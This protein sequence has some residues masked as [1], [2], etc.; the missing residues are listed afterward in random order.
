MGRA[1]TIDE[2]G[3]LGPL[4]GE[5]AWH[6]ITVDA[7]IADRSRATLARVREI[8]GRHVR[9]QPPQ[10][11]L[12]VG[13]YAL[14]H[15]YRLAEELSADVTLFDVSASTLALGRELAGGCAR[16]PR[17][18]AGD[19]HE[20]PFEDGAFDFVLICSALHHTRDWPRVLGEMQRVLAPG[21]LLYLDNEPCTRACCCF[22]F[23][24]NRP[25]EFTPFEAELDRLGALQ[26]IA[27]PFAGSRPE[28]LFG[29]VENER[30]GLDELLSQLS[31]GMDVAELTLDVATQIGPLEAGWLR[32]RASQVESR[33]R[34][35][36]AHA[37]ARASIHLD[38]QARG[39]GFS[40]PDAHEIDALAAQTAAAIRALPRRPLLARLRERFAPLPPASASGARKPHPQPGTPRQQQLARLFGASVR[41]LSRKQGTA[42]RPPAGRL[43]DTYPVRDGIHRAFT[44]A[45]AAMLDRYMRL[46]DPAQPHLHFDCD[47]WEPMRGENGIDCM[48]L[49]GRR[50]RIRLPARDADALLVLRCHGAPL[51]AGHA[52]ITIGTGDAPLFA[53][54][55]WQPESF[56]CTARLEPHDDAV[57][58]VQVVTDSTAPAHLNVAVATLHP[59]PG[60]RRDAAPARD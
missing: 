19:F 11:I 57:L 27:Q 40:L 5:T 54:E 41:A 9:A 6:M 4:L 2:Q 50:G 21:G 30:I 49:R 38:A 16:P 22:R 42:A 29:M 59:M 7:T 8:L 56:L 34:R 15:G 48:L 20:L 31:S 35:D 13:S 28:A 32:T 45:V 33:I 18:V 47:D 12:E 58:C 17:L 36:L 10:Q 46:F 3:R 44:P 26:T 43:R 24:T 60:S 52:T 39:L 37:C 23:E 1:L 51:Q 53:H 25:A 14:T 55:L